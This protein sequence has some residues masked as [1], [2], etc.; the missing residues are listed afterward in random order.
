M[1]PRSSWR[2]FQR[3]QARPDL[4]RSDR[5]GALEALAGALPGPFGRGAR[6]GGGRDLSRA[7]QEVRFVG[8]PAIAD[9]EGERRRRALAEELLQL[10]LVAASEQPDR[11]EIPPM[12]TQ[13]PIVRFEEA[14]LASSIVTIPAVL[15]FVIRGAV[16]SSSPDSMPGIG[17]DVAELQRGQTFRA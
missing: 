8:A 2:T 5:E 7:Y 9:A 12:R 4:S 10:R 17:P 1:P 11:P 13:R 14:Q 3:S 16:P 6:L 15:A